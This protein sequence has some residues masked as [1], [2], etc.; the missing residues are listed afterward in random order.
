MSDAFVS[1]F[2]WS[3]RL[4]F[5]SASLFIF[6]NM[7]S[8]AILLLNTSIDTTALADVFALVQIW[9]PFNLG[10]FI[11]W[12]LAGIGLTLSYKLWRRAYAF[13]NDIIGW[14]DNN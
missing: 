12:V 9:L 13:I 11:T 2:K 3:I 4:T 10:S 1:I 5:I 8:L 7:L 14:S 6:L